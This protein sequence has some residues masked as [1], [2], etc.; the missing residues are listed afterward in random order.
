MS[1]ESEG[2]YHVG[3]P[4]EVLPWLSPEGPIGPRQAKAGTGR[5]GEQAGDSMDKGTGHQG[6]MAGITGSLVFLTV[7]DLFRGHQ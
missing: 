6:S 7:T 3:S 2:G 1:W 5:K 4:E